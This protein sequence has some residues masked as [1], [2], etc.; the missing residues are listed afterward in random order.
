VSEQE[1][2]TALATQAEWMLSHS[3]DDFR[4]ARQA[5]G[6]MKRCWQAERKLRE[7]Q[8]AAQNCSEVVVC[9]H[10]SDLAAGLRDEAL[11]I[12]EEAERT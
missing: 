3:A 8:D 1:R 5:Y 7:A 2:I 9:E 4:V 11:A 10:C 6:L 12:I